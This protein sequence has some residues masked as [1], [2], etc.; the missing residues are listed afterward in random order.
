M[1]NTE[2]EKE[3]LR[4]TARTAGGPEGNAQS[5]LRP[6]ADR[7]ACGACERTEP[8]RHTSRPKD[9]GPGRT[10]QRLRASD[11]L[12]SNSRRFNPR[13]PSSRGNFHAIPATFFGVI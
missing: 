10:L 13:L 4:K 1:P 9:D 5:H 3:W 6:R 12:L 11:V 8:G 2:G 7:T